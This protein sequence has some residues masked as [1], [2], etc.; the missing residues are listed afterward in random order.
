[1]GKSVARIA[2]PEVVPP[3]RD[4]D[5]M[6]TSEFFRRYEAM[7]EGFRAELLNGVVYVNRW[8]ESNAE[9]ESVL[10]P[11]ISHEGHADEQFS[12]IQFM[13]MYCLSTP[14]VRGSGPTMFR[15]THPERCHAN[16]PAFSGRLLRRTP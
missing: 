1:M 6:N 11:P 10:M 3:L 2:T 4:G 16:H 7:P 14:G 13:G 12:F 9:G 15:S 5:R 8:F